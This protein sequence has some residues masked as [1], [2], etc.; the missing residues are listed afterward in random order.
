MS[1]TSVA[2]RPRHHVES[3]PF[4]ELENPF[5]A[6]CV[7]D[8][9]FFVTLY[10]IHTNKF[11]LVQNLNLFRFMLAPNAA[12]HTSTEY[13]YI[14]WICCARNMKGTR[15]FGVKSCDHL[16]AATQIIV[17]NTS[18]VLVYLMQLPY[19][20]FLFFESFPLGSVCSLLCFMCF[21]FSELMLLACHSF[22]FKFGAAAAY[23]VP[24]P[25]LNRRIC[26]PVILSNVHYHWPI[27]QSS[28]LAWKRNIFTF[29]NNSSI[30]FPVHTPGSTS[31]WSYIP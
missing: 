17:S 18:T 11:E 21:L 30:D 15:G 9:W 20:C 6:L 29:K 27:S 2:A 24:L 13:M 23:F 5:T 3:S 12:L 26:V 19:F 22:K 31:S 14:C 25:Q 4:L 16:N 10:R 1:G 7:R 28:G 8:F